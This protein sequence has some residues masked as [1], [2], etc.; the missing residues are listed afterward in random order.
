MRVLW[1]RHR[2]HCCCYK[3]FVQSDEDP[4]IQGV[5]CRVSWAVIETPIGSAVLGGG[6]RHGTAGS[7][8]PK[9]CLNLGVVASW[10]ASVLPA[11]LLQRHAGSLNTARGWLVRALLCSTLQSLAAKHTTSC[12]DVSGMALVLVASG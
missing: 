8:C 1:F 5:S 9:G 3:H 7:A 4:R 6:S 11:L 12:L 10:I 2:Q